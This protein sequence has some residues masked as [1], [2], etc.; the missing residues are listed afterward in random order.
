MLFTS[1]LS[2]GLFHSLNI[3]NLSSYGAPSSRK[4]DNGRM[5]NSQIVKNFQRTK[6]YSKD[7][8]CFHLLA[9]E[10]IQVCQRFQQVRLTPPCLD[11]RTRLVD[12]KDPYHSIEMEPQPVLLDETYKEGQTAFDNFTCPSCGHQNQGDETIS[13]EK[14]IR[15]FPDPQF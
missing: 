11:S 1:A 3:L 7:Q 14:C 4:A 9:M 6:I 12:P 8:V 5:S 15:C 2:V 10:I 13:C